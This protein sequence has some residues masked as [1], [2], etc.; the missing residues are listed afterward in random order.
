MSQPDP[1][2]RNT[3]PSARVARVGALVIVI[4]LGLFLVSW[5]SGVRAGYWLMKDAQE[6]IAIVTKDL[7]TGHN[8]VAYRYAVN[9]KEYTGKGMRNYQDPRYRNVHPGDKSVVYY[10][11]SH[12]WMSSLRRPDRIGEGLP[13]VLLVLLFEAM[14]VITLINPQHKWAFNIN[15]RARA[16]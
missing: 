3:Q 2:A 5:I 16:Q 6:G 4:V 10:S 13:V 15:G 9:H 12:P 1:A 14:A 7:W 8:G 11:A